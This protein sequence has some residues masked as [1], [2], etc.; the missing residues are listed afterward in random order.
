MNEKK[1]N[2]KSEIKPRRIVLEET[3][4]SC[5]S[6][7]VLRDKDVEIRMSADKAWNLITTEWKPIDS[8][9]PK[10]ERLLI[11]FDDGDIYVGIL[12][13]MDDGSLY[14]EDP[15]GLDFCYGHIPTHY[16]KLPEPPSTK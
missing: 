7:L 8:G 9:T 1:L 6:I 14:W 12:R 13:Q 5:D 15:D 11:A 16:M 4:Y 3:Q 10:N 2:M